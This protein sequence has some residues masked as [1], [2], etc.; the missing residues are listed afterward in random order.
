MTRP[1]VPA[2]IEV[3]DVEPE[4]GEVVGEAAR[5][6]VPRVTVLSEPVDEQ[7]DAARASLVP[8]EPLANHR[9]RHLARSDDDL[10]HERLTLVSIDGLVDVSTEEDQSCVRSCTLV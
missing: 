4:R 8:R 5:R 6:K 3:E 2:K 7:D 1:P 9:Q 10:L